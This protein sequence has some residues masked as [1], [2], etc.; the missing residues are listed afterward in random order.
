MPAQLTSRETQRKDKARVL[1]D[2]GGKCDA[3]NFH[4][5]AQYEK[6]VQHDIGDIDRQEY[7]QR[8]AG[9][10]QPEE[11]TDQHVVGQR[12][13]RA[14]DAYRE[15]LQGVGLNVGL[16]AD[17]THSQVANRC[18]RRNQNERDHQRND[19][20]LAQRYAQPVIV[21]RPKALRRD[22]RRAHAQKIHA[23]IDEAENNG[24]YCNSAKVDRAVEVA[25]HAG[26][27]HAEQGHGN[28]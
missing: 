16:R 6:Q 25:G 20:G 17:Q 27:D 11:P 19:D 23:C 7:V 4:A 21:V 26:I 10:L 18:L 15:I 3:I 13:R 28:I 12:A 9:V 14:P 5:K 24:A 22:P 1:G 2:H 8:Y